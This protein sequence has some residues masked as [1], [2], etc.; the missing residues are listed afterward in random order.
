MSGG[1]SPGTRGA[2][3][4]PDLLRKENRRIAAMFDAVAPRYDLLNH[5]LSLGTDVRWRR[6][7]VRA[8]DGVPGPVLDLCTGTGDVVLAICRRRPDVF[9]AGVDFAPEMLW[10]GRDK[11]TR[12]GF[13]DRAAM[14][15]GD[16]TELAVRAGSIGA[17][18][19]AFGIRNVEST[20]EAIAE[21]HRVLRPG[22]RAA[23]LEF[24]MPS[25]RWLRAA[26]LFYFRRV[27]PRVGAWI[28][29]DGSAYRYL[30]LSVL[31]YPMGEAFRDLLRAGG[32]ED[33]RMRPLS[34]GIATLYTGEKAPGERR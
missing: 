27:L 6:A 15:L 18:T 13:G 25:S 9:C 29:G 7:L 24:S 17:V 11:V 31:D 30:P 22:G 28:S 33:V 5:L 26:Y 12:A 19:I 1:A 4:P 21:M 23:V 2:A 10:R 20:R 16:A 8:I 14:T 3:A 32:F 34:G